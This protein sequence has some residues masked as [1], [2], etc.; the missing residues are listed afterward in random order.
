M[1]LKSNELQLDFDCTNNMDRNGWL[2]KR[3]CCDDINRFGTAGTG[4]HISIIKAY[5]DG[6][7]SDGAQYVCVANL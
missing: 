5:V 6:E 7:V 2:A 3:D 1:I 4:K